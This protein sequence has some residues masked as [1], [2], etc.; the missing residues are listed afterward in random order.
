MWSCPLRIETGRYSALPVSERTCSVC[1][2]E[3]EDETHMLLKCLLYDAIRTELFN[4][5]SQINTDFTSYNDSEKFK[6]IMSNESIVKYSAKT[7]ND[8]LTVRR[9][10]LYN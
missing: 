1:T 8:I 9:K 7:C 6:F 3:V 10:H 4:T 5:I 2:L